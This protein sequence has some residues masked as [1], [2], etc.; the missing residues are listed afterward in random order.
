MK[1]CLPAAQESSR[2]PPKVGIVSSRCMD[3]FDR[4]EDTTF[5]GVETA[6]KAVVHKDEVG[7]Y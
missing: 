4:V 2:P 3:N 7:T 5:H 1:L 6:E